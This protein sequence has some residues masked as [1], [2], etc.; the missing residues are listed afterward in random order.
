MVILAALGAVTVILAG[1]GA[2]VKVLGV[3]VTVNRSADLVT[4][5]Q[6]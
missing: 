3:A 6:L 4:T 1:A 5:H 2:V